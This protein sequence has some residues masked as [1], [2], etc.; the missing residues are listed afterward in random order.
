MYHDGPAVL[1]ED[2]GHAPLFV[3]H[4]DGRDPQTGAIKLRHLYCAECAALVKDHRAG[5]A[6]DKAR[7]AI[8]DTIEDLP[9]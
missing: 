5:V 7:K 6:F 2:C 3:D 4:I 1:K 9:S 8:P